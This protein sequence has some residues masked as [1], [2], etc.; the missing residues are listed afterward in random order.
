VGGV[1]GCFLR[2]VGAGRL[3]RGDFLIHP[4]SVWSSEDYPV[5]GLTHGLGL[6]GHFTS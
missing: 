2:G 1:F 5:L 4:G 3:R 6:R